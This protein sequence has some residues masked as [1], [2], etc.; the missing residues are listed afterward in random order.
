M[1]TVIQPCRNH[2][3][4]C[5]AAILAWLSGTAGAAPIFTEYFD[6]VTLDPLLTNRNSTPISGGQ[7][8]LNG[9]NTTAQG[10]TYSLSSYLDA[11]RQF[12]TSW[13]AEMKL[14]TGAIQALNTGNAD[15]LFTLAGGITLRASW[16]YSPTLDLTTV[17]NDGGVGFDGYD[18]T[19]IS[20]GIDALTVGDHLALVYTRDTLPENDTLVYYRNGAQVASLSGRFD[21]PVGDGGYTTTGG[22]G[23]E[24]NLYAPISRGFEVPLDAVAFSTFTGSFSPSGGFALIPEPGA[25]LLGGLGL[26]AL[27]RRRR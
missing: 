18:S 13:V 11:N 9:A 22:F 3:G 10:L 17:I 5:A 1:R 8:T 21:M 15:T 26:L 4:L 6:D 19:S 7:A 25:A 14:G 12:T 24:V 16:P 27:L 2:P 23:L 20:G